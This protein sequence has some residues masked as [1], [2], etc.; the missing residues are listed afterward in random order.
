MLHTETMD[1][2]ES[3]TNM[4]LQVIGTDA[5]LTMRIVKLIAAR[6]ERQKR[7]QEIINKLK[8]WK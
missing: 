7:K 8:F 2:K 5:V 4:K 1:L 6:Q 3:F